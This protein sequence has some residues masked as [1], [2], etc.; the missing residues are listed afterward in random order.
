VRSVVSLTLYRR[1]PLTTLYSRLAVK[2]TAHRDVDAHRDVETHDPL[3]TTRGHTDWPLGQLSLLST[4]DSR[5][6][7]LTIDPHTTGSGSLPR[8]DSKAGRCR[9]RACLT[10]RAAG[11]DGESPGQARS[12][13]TV[14]LDPGSAGT[15]PTRCQG[16]TASHYDPAEPC[17]T[18]TPRQ[19][20]TDAAGPGR[21]RV[22]AGPKKLVARNLR[23]G[24]E[25][26]TAALFLPLSL[27]H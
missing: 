27:P 20:R 11:P 1:S 3:L 24:Y 26:A 13:F 12:L 17:R 10:R 16:Q 5:W 14:T 15:S 2:P 9:F 22:D 23:L 19:T 6:S 21:A 4:H 7:L 18:A 8:P 25:G